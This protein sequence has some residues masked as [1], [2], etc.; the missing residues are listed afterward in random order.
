MT[1]RSL[2]S[3]LPIP[4]SEELSSHILMISGALR[5]ESEDN[6]LQRLLV[7]QLRNQV[8]DGEY[9]HPRQN[10]CALFTCGGG[11]EFSD[12]MCRI[13]RS[14]R[15]AAL[16]YPWVGTHFEGNPE[17]SADYITAVF[18]FNRDQ[19]NSL[20]MFVFPDRKRAPWYSHFDQIQVSKIYHVGSHILLVQ[21][22]PSLLR[23][24]HRQ[25]V[26]RVTWA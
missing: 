18:Y 26:L 22:A 24:T 17:G 11:E 25:L 10:R 15:N 14:K 3:T 20:L 12:Y 7:C 13:V 5:W 23:T 16:K 9:C 19:N 1:T 4:T 2:A 21:R 6:T 8:S